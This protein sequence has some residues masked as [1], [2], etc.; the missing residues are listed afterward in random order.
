MLIDINKICDI[1]EINSELDIS[2]IDPAFSDVKV[3]GKIKKI[4]GELSIKAK[5]TGTY[6]SVCDRC[7][8]EAV[9]K[10]EA[11]LDTIFNREESKDESLT[12]ENGKIFLDK[13]A[14]DALTLEIPLVILCNEDCKGICSGCGANLNSEECRCQAE[15]D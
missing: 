2:E 11:T 8:E 7:M 13:T 14:Y 9:L 3:V 5:V 1:L 12:I 4:S 15:E 10:L 6:R